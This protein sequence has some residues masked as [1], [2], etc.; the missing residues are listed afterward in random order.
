MGNLELKEFMI[1]HGVPI[2]GVIHVGA[3]F[4]QEDILY[5]E[6]KIKNRLYFEPI[7]YNFNVLKNN[8][9]SDVKIFNLALGNEKKIVRMYV[10]SFNE[11]M[12]SSI[13]EPKLH[14]EQFP[15]IVFDNFEDVYMDRL[16]DLDINVNDYNMMNIDV[17]GYE[18][19]VLKG[20]IKTL[21]NIDYLVVEINKSELYKGCAIH[22]EIDY[23]LIENCFKC[24]DKYWWGHTFGEGFYVKNK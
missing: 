13:L 6:L 9:D 22:D 8:I 21:S 18:L 20:S 12:S 11:G 7:S 10:E 15:N 17:Q 14:L 1:K 16:D 4:G 24:V 19:E 3:H 5:K 23:F 2:H